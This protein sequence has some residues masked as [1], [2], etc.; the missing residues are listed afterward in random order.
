MAAE[1]QYRIGETRE[2]RDDLNGAVDAYVK[3]SILY[4]HE[5]WVPDGL[6]QAGQCY[7]RLDA[8]DK[9]QKFYKELVER[10]PESD[11]GQ[12]ARNKVRGV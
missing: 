8:K 2:A 4:A 11:A 10:F 5:P 12:K 3:L 1:S 9:A 6:W 7:E